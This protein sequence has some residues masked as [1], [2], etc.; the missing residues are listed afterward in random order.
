MR[1]LTTTPLI[2]DVELA[3]GSERLATAHGNGAQLFPWAAAGSRSL[4]TVTAAFAAEGSRRK[5]AA[6][7]TDTPRHDFPAPRIAAK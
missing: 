4:P 2:G 7:S 1:H 3:P 5:A 6:A